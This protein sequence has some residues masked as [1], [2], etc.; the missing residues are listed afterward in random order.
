MDIRLDMHSYGGDIALESGDLA[1]D[2]GL[3]TPVLISLFSDGRAGADILPVGETDPRGWWPDTA[4]DRFGS[5][6]WLLSREKML[7][8]TATRAAEYAKRAL[9]WLV[10]EGIAATVGVEA[11]L[12]PPSGLLLVVRI[13]RGQN[14]KYDYLWRGITSMQKTDVVGDNLMDLHIILE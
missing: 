5:L 10:D 2:H 14:R 4:A 6:L 7:P 12:R 8:E 13:S 1:I 9:R 11:G 3:A